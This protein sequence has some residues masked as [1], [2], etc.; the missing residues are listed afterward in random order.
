MTATVKRRPKHLDLPKIRLPM[1]AFVSILHRFSGVLLFLF[2]PFLLFLFE[3][4]LASAPS[5][6]GLAGVIG[7]PLA[8][9]VLFG[10]LWSFLHHLFAGIRYL[11]LDLHVGTDLAAARMGSAIVL[12]VSLL[13]TAILGVK[14]W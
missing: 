8:K 2:I 5:Y 6:A 3:R 9:L 12:V 7:H 11:L 10:L 14:L 1:P 13:L 4:S